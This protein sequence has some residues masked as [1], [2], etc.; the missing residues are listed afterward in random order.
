MLIRLRWFA[1]GSVAVSQVESS[2]AC[3]APLNGAIGTPE[4]PL[5]M[6]AL[7]EHGP[8]RFQGRR[9]RGQEALRRF[10]GQ[11]WSMITPCGMYMKPRRTGGLYGLGL[12]GSAHPMDSKKR[13][14]ERGSEAFE[15]GAAIDEGIYLA[16]VVSCGWN[17]A[18]Q[19]GIA[20]DDFGDER[21]HA[22]AIAWR[23]IPR[24]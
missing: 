15:A 19:E 24:G 5:T 16:L 18:I 22:V 1:S 2:S 14:G 17:V 3:G 9:R 10:V 11:N 20:G 7:I 8:Q 4:M 12:P 6:Q 21:L 13:Q 23:W